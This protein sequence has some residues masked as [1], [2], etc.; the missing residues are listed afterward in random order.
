[1]GYPVVG[2][3]PTVS[4]T[5]FVRV[6]GERFVCFACCIC[7]YWRYIADNMSSA[8]CSCKP[9]S[10]DKAPSADEETAP[11]AHFF[12]SEEA[13]ESN[14]GIRAP[15]SVLG[16]YLGGKKKGGSFHKYLKGNQV[17]SWMYVK[18][19]R[20]ASDQTVVDDAW[21]NVA[22][23]NIPCISSSLRKVPKKNCGVVQLDAKGTP[24]N[25]LKWGQAWM[26]VVDLYKCQE[27]DLELYN[28]IKTICLPTF[29]YHCI[30]KQGGVKA[31][32][33]THQFEKA[34]HIMLMLSDCG[35][36][37]PGTG[38]QNVFQS[39]KNTVKSLSSYVV[40]SNECKFLVLGF[41]FL[42]DEV[43]LPKPHPLMLCN[44]MYYGLRETPGRYVYV[45]IICS[46][47]S[48][49]KYMMYELLRDTRE[50]PIVDMMFKKKGVSFM[51]MLR[52]VPSVYT[53]YA[54]MYGF[55][56]TVDNRSVFPI[57]FVDV[58]DLRD[59]LQKG[60]LL[61]DPPLPLDASASN[62]EIMR[63]IF[64]EKETTTDVIW[65]A[66]PGCSLY[67]VYRLEAP[68]KNFLIKNGMVKHMMKRTSYFPN[69]QVFY[70][71]DGSSGFLFSKLVTKG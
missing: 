37:Q 43:R 46:R 44:A 63:T 23:E 21:S 61:L 26:L 3:I 66:P 27:N 28:L 39:F 68:F 11:V 64:G 55:T 6:W 67:R 47:F 33:V 8:K 4:I 35:N 25:T 42:M 38:T 48:V 31:G 7:F 12:A 69:V 5:S 51:C 70:G 59:G 18:H 34:S 10:R 36:V 50:N 40:P 17:T 52:A 14:D 32:Y 57:F 29:G 65:N 16:N 56:R 30:S 9:I 2:S 62:E 1:M 71:D 54:L 53:Y 49:A 41:S 45:D 20:D 19:V 13:Y 15:A 24:Q 22:D 60:D 58:D